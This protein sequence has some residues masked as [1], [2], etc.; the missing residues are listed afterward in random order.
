MSYLPINFSLNFNDN[1]I[2][3]KSQE[4][5]YQIPNLNLSSTIEYKNEIYKDNKNANINSLSLLNSTDNYKEYEKCEKSYKMMNGEFK[6]KD[7]DNFAINKK[8]KFYFKV[9]HFLL[10]SINNIE[11]KKKLI[12]EIKNLGRK[13]KDDKSIRGHDKYSDD[14]IIRK[15]KHLILNCIMNFINEKIKEIYNGNIGNNIFKKE[16]LTLN[17]FQKS[18]AQINYNKEFLTKTLEEI[19]SETIS[20]RFTNYL[21]QHNKNVIK[22][23]EN[24]EDIEKRKYFQKLFNLNFLQC[25]KH[26]RKE[27]FFEELNGLKNFNEIKD[28]LIEEKEYISILEYYIDNYEVIIISKMYK[29]TITR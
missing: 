25:L 23:L 3:S 2:D 16:L 1:Q 29:K 14:N 19:F 27:E 18:N 22:S 21:P 4:N 8:K 7:I 15:C 20:S 13:K 28:E 10:Y 12:T 26:I 24:E 11:S 6:H 17:K 9:N 5:N